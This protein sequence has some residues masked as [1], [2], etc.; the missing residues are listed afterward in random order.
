MSDLKTTFSRG[1]SILFNL[2]SISVAVIAVVNVYEF[3]RNNIWTPTV[4]VDKVDFNSAVAKSYYQ[5]KKI[6][7]EGRF[8]F[9]Y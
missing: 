4:V 2:A 8:C 7:F 3:Y 9:P 1:K 6:C 5:W